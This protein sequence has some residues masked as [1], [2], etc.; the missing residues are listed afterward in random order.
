MK[1]VKP[2]WNQ[3]RRN[4]LEDRYLYNDEKDWNDLVERISSHVNAEFWD[5]AGSIEL[6]QLVTFAPQR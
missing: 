4:V 3:E 2:K 1:V 6:Y 5:I